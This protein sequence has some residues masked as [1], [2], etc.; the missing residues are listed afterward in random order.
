VLDH[1]V[2]LPSGETVHNP[3]RVLANGDGSEV[4]FTLY[5]RPAVS[6]AEYEA[7]AAAVAADLERLKAL[8]EA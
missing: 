5:R 8:L 4:V 3:M 2:T 6:D 1:D 7:D